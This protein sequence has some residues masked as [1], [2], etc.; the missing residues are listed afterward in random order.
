M[1]DVQ[2]RSR[3]LLADQH[4]E[5]CSARIPY[6]R[7]PLKAVEAV[8]ESEVEDPVGDQVEGVNA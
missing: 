7:D 2:D 4:A 3:F 8:G 5:W 6:L 1:I